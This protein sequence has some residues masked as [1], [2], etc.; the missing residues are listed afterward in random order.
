MSASTVETT[1]MTASTIAI[2]I[3]LYCVFFFNKWLRRAFW[4]FS[5]FYFSSFTKQINFLFKIP[6]ISVR[7]ATKIFLYIIFSRV[8]VYELIAATTNKLLK[9]LQR[10][11]YTCFSTFSVPTPNMLHSFVVATAF[12]SFRILTAWCVYAPAYVYVYVV[13]HCCMPK[14]VYMQSLLNYSIQHRCLSMYLCCVQF[15]F[16]C[17]PNVFVLCNL[18]LLKTFMHLCMVNMYYCFVQLFRL[19]MYKCCVSM[20]FVYWIF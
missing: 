1:T 19:C 7:W 9:S 16:S 5:S 10:S 17:Y 4:I 12:R 11:K 18:K 6:Q 20:C 15:F 2:N 14:S 8:H 3:H 13:D